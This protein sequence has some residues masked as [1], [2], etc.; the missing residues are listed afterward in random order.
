MGFVFAVTSAQA[1]CL[2]LLLQFY[3]YLHKAKLTANYTQEEWNF[4]WVLNY[5]LIACSLAKQQLARAQKHPSSTESAPNVSMCLNVSAGVCEC[6]YF[7]TAVGKISL[8]AVCWS[9]LLS[10]RFKIGARPFAVA[11]AVSD[12]E[13]VKSISMLRPFFFCWLCT[14]SCFFCRLRGWCYYLLV[15][16]EENFL[17]QKPSAVSLLTFLSRSLALHLS[18]ALSLQLNFPLLAQQLIGL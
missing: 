5:N 13:S 3:F 16:V 7:C 11:V 12:F 14:Y 2:P 6:V 10:E 15:V 9:G 4:Q 8:V 18:N 1:I 17:M